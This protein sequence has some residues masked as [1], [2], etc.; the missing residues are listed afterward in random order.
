[1]TSPPGIVPS[2]TEYQHL[3][4]TYGL[5]S[6]D[7]VEFPSSGSSIMSPPPRKLG[8][9]QK[10][11]RLPLTDFQ[12]EVLQKDGYS[13]QMLTPNIVNNVVAFEMICRT[14][15]YLPDYFVFKY[16]FRFCCIGDK[17]TFFVRQRGHTL[18]PDGRTPK[19]LPQGYGG[20][21]ANVGLDTKSSE[22]D[23]VVIGE[24]VCVD[25][26]VAESGGDVEEFLEGCGSERASADNDSV[27]DGKGGGGGRDP[28][29]G[30]PCS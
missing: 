5:S 19:L 18:V 21:V 26:V 15:G 10:V 8:I 13:V 30:A 29:T 4:S 23:H 20:V 25:K 2:A 9:Y 28:F 17:Y 12:E 27:G 1:M 3:E 24:H 6:L 16:F 7:G 14:N 22:D 11:I